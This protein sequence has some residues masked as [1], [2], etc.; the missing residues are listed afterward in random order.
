VSEGVPSIQLI[1]FDY[2]LASTLVGPVSVKKSDT[3][4][5]LSHFVKVDSGVS[6][7]VLLNAD[8]LEETAA[9]SESKIFQML[10]FRKYSHL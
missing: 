4:I 7:L 5:V 3:I 2:S 1:F 6:E 10:S 8:G 9:T